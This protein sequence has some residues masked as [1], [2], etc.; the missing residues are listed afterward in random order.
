M[1]YKGRPRKLTDIQLRE[2]YDLYQNGTSMVHLIG[3]Y[4]VSNNTLLRGFVR[5]NL[6]KKAS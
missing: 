3:K 2:A 6:I 1:N 4:G 5:L